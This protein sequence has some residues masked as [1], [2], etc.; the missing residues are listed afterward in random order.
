MT[1]NTKNRDIIEVHG[2]NC[3]NCALGIK[4]QLEKNGFQL[5]DAN[6]SS[7]EISFQ[8]EENS[9]LLKAKNINEQFYLLYGGNDLHTLL[10]TNKQ[11]SIISEYYINNDK[12]RP[13]KP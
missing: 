13:Y 11:F 5:V 6:F 2:M 3:T 4:K 7:N 12:Q 8:K 10:L 1:A 9:R